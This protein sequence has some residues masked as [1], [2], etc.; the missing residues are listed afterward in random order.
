[1][2]SKY[3]ILSLILLVCTFASCH[4]NDHFSSRLLF[5]EYWSIAGMVLVAVFTALAYL[6]VSLFAYGIK[7][8]GVYEYEIEET[9][10]GT[11][12]YKDDWGVTTH[13]VDF[14][15][16]VG[17]GEYD[18]Y[19][20]TKQEE[21]YSIIKHNLDIQ[22]GRTCACL[23][24]VAFLL[25]TNAIVTAE[26]NGDLLT[27]GLIMG[28]TAIIIYLYCNG[29]AA[30]DSP[31]VLA[32][33]SD[34]AKYLRYTYIFGFTLFFVCVCIGDDGFMALGIGLLYLL[35]G[36]FGVGYGVATLLDLW[37]NLSN[38]AFCAITAVVSVPVFTGL[39]KVLH[40][41]TDNIIASCVFLFL[42]N[43]FC[44]LPCSFVY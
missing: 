30:I 23:L 44:Y 25:L 27:T 12:E 11:R 1:M 16:H 9:R 6:I 17:T 22:T 21:Q 35:K 29:F 28:V 4:V 42:I 38:A 3:R 5:G 32:L 26:V 14:E 13:T 8:A 18:T 19:R 2:M 37:L 34:T 15:E 10:Y 24:S 40:K 31:I 36:I 39:F 43:L 41:W 7:K 33:A 20:I